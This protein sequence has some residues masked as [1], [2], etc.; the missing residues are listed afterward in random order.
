MELA[1]KLIQLGLFKKSEI[2]EDDVAYYCDLKHQLEDC[3][4]LLQKNETLF[5]MEQDPELI[6][7]YIYEREGLMVRY[8]HLIRQAKL[9]EIK[10]KE[11]ICKFEI[12]TSVP[13][14]IK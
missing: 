12:D 9:Q 11:K 14:K 4:A 5:N 1:A 7:S 2:K 10:D 6:E 3:K 8:S 13:V